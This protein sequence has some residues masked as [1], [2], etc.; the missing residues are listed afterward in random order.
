MNTSL[1]KYLTFYS[2]SSPGVDIHQCLSSPG[3]QTTARSQGDRRR[4]TSRYCWCRRCWGRKER[5]TLNRLLKCSW[6]KN[7]QTHPI[8]CLT[9]MPVIICLPG[10]L[11]LVNIQ[12]APLNVR[13]CALQTL[14]AVLVPVTAECLVTTP[15]ETIAYN[16]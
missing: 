9:Q 16:L 3:Q 4:R 8:M 14:I 2:D 6:N 10:V 7:I 1:H 13:P 15:G 5:S 12:T 11:A